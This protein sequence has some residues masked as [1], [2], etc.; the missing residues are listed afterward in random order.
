MHQVITAIMLLVWFFYRIFNQ[1]TNNISD[2]HFSGAESDNIVKYAILK[3]SESNYVC[4]DK[5]DFEIATLSYIFTDDLFCIQNLYDA[6]IHHKIT[7]HCLTGTLYL[8]VMTNNVV[9][10]R[11][12]KEN[13]EPNESIYNKY[14]MVIH[15]N[16]LAL[17]INTGIKYIQK[18]SDQIVLIYYNNHYFVADYLPSKSI[19]NSIIENPANNKC[20]IVC[21]ED[22]QGEFKPSY[23]SFEKEKE[24]CVFFNLLSKY[25]TAKN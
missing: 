10:A 6:V 2:N 1:Q 21:I 18:Q 5:N 20:D 3:K 8:T 14:R 4:S 22:Y 17:I 19:L 12:L 7:S 11:T 16:T 9:Y 13:E 25:Y 15:R 24:R 23:I